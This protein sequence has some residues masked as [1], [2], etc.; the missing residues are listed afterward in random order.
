MASEQVSEKTFDSVEF[1]KR[2][3][4]ALQHVKNSTTDSYSKIH[5]FDADIF[6]D[7]DLAKLERD[8]IFGAVPTIACHSSE[9]AKPNDFV[10]IQM[11]RNNLI[12]V[13]QKDGTVKSFV[14]ACRH[15]GAMVEKEEAGRARLFSCPYHRWSYDTNGDLRE[16]TRANTFGEVDR[17]QRGLIEIPTE[18]RHGFVWV[19][20]RFGADINVAEWLGEKV[21][22]ILEGFQLDKLVNVRSG[23]F[24]Y[25]IN[26][27]ITQDAFL[28]AYHIQY[29]HP[30]TAGKHVQT[31]A[32]AV[33]DFG[34]H[35]RQTTPRKTIDRWLEE[36]PGDIDLTPFVTEAYFLLPNSTLIRQPDH[37]QL[38]TFRP[39]REDPQRSIM[40]MRVLAPTIE[41]SGMDE[42][43]WHK[44]WE[45]NWQI[46]ITV[47]QN[48]DVP[49]LEGAQKAMQSDDAGSLLL[50][51]NEYM[52]H[53]FHRELAKLLAADSPVTPLPNS[54][55]GA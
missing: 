19:V 33:E 40:E 6:R 4:R 55:P 54:A 36:D 22:G 48:E 39:D 7:P 34:R 41:D 32:T 35:A 50:G 14:N 18:E 8:R 24:E 23:Q 16:I 17:R 46:L 5:Q 9:V 37:F 28:D 43:R 27:K 10:T 31:N 1:N 26:W 13:R 12:V 15:R 49:I 11:P 51:H 53:I 42:E 2:I 20:D 29:A 45:K 3:R 25:K 47:L 38:L 52:N 44:L 30:N 21:D